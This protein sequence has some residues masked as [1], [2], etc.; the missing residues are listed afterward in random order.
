MNE[1]QP[2]F[3]TR[4]VQFVADLE[5][6]TAAA[7]AAG[8]GSVAQETMKGWFTTLQQIIK[9]LPGI[10]LPP[11][12]TRRVYRKRQGPRAKPT[13]PKKLSPPTA[14][15]APGP[16]MVPIQVPPMFAGPPLLVYYPTYAP[17]CT[18]PNNPVFMQP[19]SLEAHANAYN[20]MY[21]PLPNP[22]FFVQPPG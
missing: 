9:Q 5:K 10:D 6:T 11:P 15:S 20:P 16:L 22:P 3:T 1:N 17:I 13:K 12:P 2:H 21:M 7:Q 8:L 14:A 18:L 4:L 19:P